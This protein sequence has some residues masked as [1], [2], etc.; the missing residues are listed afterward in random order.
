MRHRLADLASIRSGYQFRGGLKDETPD[1]EPVRVMQIKYVEVG[2][3]LPNEVESVR[4]RKNVEAY[5]VKQGDV[6]FLGRGRR[7]G[8]TLVD[9][10]VEGVTPAY[11]T[12]F[13]NHPETQAALMSLAHK[14]NIP[15]ISRSVVEELEVDVPSLE[16]QN[17]IAQ[18]DQLH[19]REQKLAQELIEKRVQWMDALT[20]QIARR[21]PQITSRRTL[22]YENSR[23]TIAAAVPCARNRTAARS[24]RG[25]ARSRCRDWKPARSSHAQARA[26]RHHAR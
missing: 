14:T 16:T 19:R 10:P 5:A 24:P 17:Q 4:P 1:T 23:S 18:L 21:Q 26:H 25:G 7:F 11:L 12:W 3:F 6:L 15:V 13:L 2:N 9:V 22:L 20:L 8:A